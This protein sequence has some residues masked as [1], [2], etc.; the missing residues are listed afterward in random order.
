MC[1][2][3]PFTTL[4]N[5]DILYGEPFYSACAN[6]KES[7]IEFFAFLLLLIVIFRHRNYSRE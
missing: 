2:K 4:C 1:K 6:H 5:K 3:I 7:Q